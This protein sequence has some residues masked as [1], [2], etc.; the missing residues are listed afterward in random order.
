MHSERPAA[1]ASGECHPATARCAQPRRCLLHGLALLALV[2]LHANGVVL[3]T[4][5]PEAEHRHGVRAGTVSPKQQGQP[6]AEPRAAEAANDRAGT[7][8]RR[9]RCHSPRQTTEA[10]GAADPRTGDAGGAGGAVAASAGSRRRT[11]AVS[12]DPPARRRRTHPPASPRC[13]ARE[14]RALDTA[15]VAMTPSATPAAA[16]VAPLLPAH[17]VAGMESDRPP[18]YP[19]TCPAAR[20]AR[21]GPAASEC[22]RRW[23]AASRSASRR[24]AASRASM[25]RRVTA[26]QQWRFVPATPRQARPSPRRG[27]CRSASGSLSEPQ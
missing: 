18:V 2:C 12:A 24:A 25:P 4:P 19:E 23:A 6:R 7:G 26:V 9:Q 16:L 27:E 20:P 21:P 3:L 5:P 22:L 14:H 11:A 8:F 10:A 17:P 15:A 13:T 1:S